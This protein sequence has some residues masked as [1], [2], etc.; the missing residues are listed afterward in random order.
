M[1]C[2]PIHYTVAGMKIDLKFAALG[3]LVLLLGFGGGY[4]LSTP[5]DEFAKPDFS[6]ELDSECRLNQGACQRTLEQGGAVQF[7]VGPQPILGAAPLY[8]EL[9]VE[10]LDIRRA[11]VD[12]SGVDMNM[13]SY[14]FELEV[15]AQGRYRAE[16]ILPV[17]VRNRMVWRA[18]LWLQTRKR[19]LLRIPYQF[20]AFKYKD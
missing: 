18:D 17:C 14:R 20:T 16:G 9:D 6:L 2:L 12:L 19:G 5:E 4:L 15:D 8:F 11:A 7:A 1:T 13:G 10:D 3:S